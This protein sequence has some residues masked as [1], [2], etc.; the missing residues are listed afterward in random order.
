MLQKTSKVENEDGYGTREPVTTVMD[1]ALCYSTR[2]PLVGVRQLC[3][4]GRQGSGGS[5]LPL[6]RVAVGLLVQLV[7]LV[8]VSWSQEKEERIYHLRTQECV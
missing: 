7:H 2:D 8:E 6:L 4:V 1:A 5:P 3:P